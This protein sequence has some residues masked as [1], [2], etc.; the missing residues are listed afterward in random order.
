[1][2][3]L[4]DALVDYRHHLLDHL[5]RVLRGHR[6]LLL[7]RDSREVPLVEVPLPDFPRRRHPRLREILP[8]RVVYDVR[9]LAL[10]LKAI[11]PRRLQHHL[12]VQLVRHPNLRGRYG[13]RPHLDNPA[14]SLIRHRVLLHRHRQVVPLGY[15]S[16]ERLDAYH[17]RRVTDGRERVDRRLDLVVLLHDRRKLGFLR[18]D[19]E[20][21]KRRRPTRRREQRHP[22]QVQVVR[23]R[24]QD[25]LL[26]DVRGVGIQPLLERVRPVQHD[27]PVVLDP[28]G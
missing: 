9:L 24:H 14:E 15:H 26:L 19:V 4:G 5:V 13:V 18:V 1:M 12:R 17:H 6:D 20:E 28:L 10:D 3:Q 7:G 23:L 2:R 16:R 22:A 27:V 25:V 11:V 8:V 21:R